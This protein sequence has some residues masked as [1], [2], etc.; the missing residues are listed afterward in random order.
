[1]SDNCLFC[2]I[3]AGEIP[4]DTLYEDDEVMAFRDIS[5]EAPTHFLVIPKRHLAGPS[6]MTPEDEGLIGKVLRVGADLAKDNG[7]EHF[8]FVANSGADAG[9]RVFHFHLHV[10]GGR[11]MTWPPG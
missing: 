6:S 3:A 10:L 5:P 8:R 1:M 4:A 11:K 7:A 9:Q 2:R